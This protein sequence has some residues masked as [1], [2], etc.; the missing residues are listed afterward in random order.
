MKS[1]RLDG[2]PGIRLS[3]MSASTVTGNTG[4]HNTD[5]SLINSKALAEVGAPADTVTFFEFYGA[6][7]GYSRF[8][9]GM[10]SNNGEPPRRPRRPL[11]L[12]GRW[13]S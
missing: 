2:K 11:P 1:N 13:I 6:D 12:S 7:S 10:R 5:G 4:D 3:N 9:V 8:T